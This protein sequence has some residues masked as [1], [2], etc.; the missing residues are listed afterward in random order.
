MRWLWLA[1]CVLVLACR[2][3]APGLHVVVE[4]SLFPRTD[5]DRL[6]VT[7][8]RAG[9]GEPLSEVRFEGSELI[10]LPAS[11]NFLAGKTTPPGTTLEVEATAYLGD[12]QVARGKVSAV[13][14]VAE[15]LSLRLARVFE[16]EPPPE[17]PLEPLEPLDPDVPDAGEPPASDGGQVVVDGGPGGPTLKANAE[18]CAAASECASGFCV[19]GVCC[20]GGCASACGACNLSGKVGQCAPLSAG[21][22]GKTSCAPY[23]CDG[24]ALACPSGCSSDAA[25]V[26]GLFCRA[27]QCVE[28]L[29]SVRDNFNAASRDAATWNTFTCCGTGASVSQSSQRLQIST[30]ASASGYAGYKTVKRY[31]GRDAAVKVELVSAGNQGLAGQDVHF[32]L[33][34]DASHTAGFTIAGGMISAGKKV[35]GTPSMVKTAAF[36]AT[37]MRHLRLRESQGTLH[38]ETSSDGQTFASFASQATPFAFDQ[39][40]IDL[41]AG[42][43]QA[44]SSGAQVS[45]DNLN[46]P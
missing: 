16:Q 13:V 32:Q 19:D 6:V 26:T 5:F 23:V 39:V 11:V 46:M 18:P 38:W 36:N 4:G 31:E 44:E 37:S 3:S 17:E 41:V 34:R 28:T 22:P 12:G 27:G 7:T 33:V 15:P 45:F 2:P 25:C 43:Y 20:N 24:A 8:Y 29:S 9:G 30:T 42:V 40:G 21:S 14:G 35:A 10:P 1:G